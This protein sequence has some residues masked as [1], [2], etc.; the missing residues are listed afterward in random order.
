M[1]KKEA[2]R[3]KKIALWNVTYWFVQPWKAS[4]V[5][6]FSEYFTTHISKGLLEQIF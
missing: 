2:Q 5:S 4:P 3:G 1:L 6:L